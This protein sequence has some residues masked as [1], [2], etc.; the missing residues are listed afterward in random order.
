[1]GQF[2]SVVKVIGRLHPQLKR[3]GPAIIVSYKE[4]R[5]EKACRAGRMISFFGLPPV[6]ISTE[7]SVAAQL[8]VIDGL[9]ADDN[10]KLF[11]YDGSILA[12]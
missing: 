3:R 1:M 8:K 7:E 12:F 2:C 9:S 6:A 4:K 5:N 10:G 11:N